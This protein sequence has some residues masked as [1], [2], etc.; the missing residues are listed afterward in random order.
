MKAIVTKRKK[1]IL[2]SERMASKW[3]IV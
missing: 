2:P 3:L 1:A